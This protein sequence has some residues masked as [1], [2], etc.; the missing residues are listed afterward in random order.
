MK[1]MFLFFLLI[2]PLKQ[3]LEHQSQPIVLLP[4][5]SYHVD[6]KLLDI[7]KSNH[8]VY[9]KTRYN[10]KIIWYEYSDSLRKI[11]ILGN[12]RI[13]V[14]DFFFFNNQSFF[15][16][17]RP[18]RKYY[19]N[20]NKSNSFD[21]LASLK[22][23]KISLDFFPSRIFIVNNNIILGH[24]DLHKKN[25][26][27]FHRY[28]LSGRFINSFAPAISLPD[29]IPFYSVYYLASTNY[30]SGIG[31]IVTYRFLPN[32]FIFNEDGK[33]TQ[34]YFFNK[35][36][37]TPFFYSYDP[38]IK[39]GMKIP[40]QRLLG[41]PAVGKSGYLWLPIIK[42]ND[43]NTFSELYLLDKRKIQKKYIINELKITAIEFSN[44]FEMLYT[45]SPNRLSIFRVK[46]KMNR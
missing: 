44:N 16:C 3:N 5:K 40:K 43:G 14:V 12:T 15:L 20:I 30:F 25:K 34:K 29:T 2:S 32:I 22:M 37:P 18:D 36:P 42:N 17:K 19:V 11:N 4:E 24:S 38:N 31:F 1:T 26:F 6:G 23:I 13:N 7:K 35:I 10:S 46:V 33:M 39:F 41:Q 8:K 21:S 27:Y 9:L 45:I 28:S